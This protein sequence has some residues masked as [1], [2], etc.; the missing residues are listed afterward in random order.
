MARSF[1]AAGAQVSVAARTADVLKTLADEVGGQ[2]FE[3]DLLDQEQTEGLIDRAELQVGPIDVLVN[4]AGMGPTS[5]ITNSDVTEI[6]NT[7]RLN[8][9]APMILTHKVLPGMLA[10][11]RGH[12][13]VTSSL[14]GTGGFPGLSIYG[15]TKA[16]LTNFIASLR[17]ELKGTPVKT[18]VVAPGPIQTDMWDD[19]E[20]SQDTAPTLKR[21]RRLRLIP[22]ES[23]DN[24]GDQT[25]KAVIAGRRHVRTPRRL[26]AN[27]WLREVP[28]RMTEIGLTGA[29]TGIQ[30][31]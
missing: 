18:T 17:M 15:A 19:L 26:Q 11:G 12:I 2:A 28:S 10:R 8:L 21:F 4:N 20:E 9:E 29:K 14:A 31:R 30:Q 27:H 24:L 13:V 25:V 1:A 16:G 7:T 3:V 5:F 23:A 6:T 22:V